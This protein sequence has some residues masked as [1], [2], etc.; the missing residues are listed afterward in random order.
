MDKIIITKKNITTNYTRSRLKL[1]ASVSLLQ[2][3][4]TVDKIKTDESRGI[5]R[6]LFNPE[7]EVCCHIVPLD[8]CGDS[9]SS[10]SLDIRL[11]L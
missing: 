3:E 1:I 6:T 8:D 2:A 10:L 7:K 9:I 4:N 5:S 11:H